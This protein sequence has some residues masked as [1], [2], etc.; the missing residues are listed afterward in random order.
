[1][2]AYTRVQSENILE[3]ALI[4][5]CICSHI[6]KVKIFQY[7]CLYM[8]EYTRAFLYEIKFMRMGKWKY[9][10]SC[11]KLHSFL[12]VGVYMYMLALLLVV[13]GLA[14]ITCS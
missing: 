13:N 11:S 3:Y 9:M 10:G 8:F 7:M 2:L 1:M 5:L 14:L 12:C 4:G 6:N